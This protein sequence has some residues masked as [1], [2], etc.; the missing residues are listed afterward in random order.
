MP[1]LRHPAEAQR[2]GSLVVDDG[3]SGLGDDLEVGHRLVWLL[4]MTRAY[5]WLSTVFQ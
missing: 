1:W 4:R 2:L 5:Q 3:Q